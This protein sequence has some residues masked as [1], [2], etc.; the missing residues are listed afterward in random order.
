VEKKTQKD[1]GTMKRQNYNPKRSSLMVESWPVAT[2]DGGSA[3]LG[4]CLPLK[5]RQKSLV[6]NMLMSEGCG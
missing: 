3:T 1:V 4:V 5:V 6:W 2:R